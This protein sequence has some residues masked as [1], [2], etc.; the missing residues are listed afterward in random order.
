MAK[1]KVKP[2]RHMVVLQDPD[3]TFRAMFWVIRGNVL[4][5]NARSLNV[6]EGVYEFREGL[7]ITK[8][9]YLTSLF[10]SNVCRNI[11]MNHPR[12]KMFVRLPNTV[13]FI[14]PDHGDLKL[15]N[16]S[17]LKPKKSYHVR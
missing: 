4:S 9:G 6:E 2:E 13:N 5:L 7:Y 16:K 14:F 12:A 1:S 15:L 10:L 8:A 11:I 17:F 3:E